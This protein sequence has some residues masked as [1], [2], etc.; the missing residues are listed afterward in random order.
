MSVR[1][2]IRVRPFNEREKKLN[3]ELCVKMSGNTVILLDE[4]DKEAKK[5]NFDYSVWSHDGFITDE[6]GFFKPKDA[7]SKYWDQTKVYN[8]MGNDL[9]ENAVQGY[10]CCLFAYGQTG[11]G[12]SYSIFGYGPNKG[13]VPIMCDRLFD[14]SKLINDDKNQFSISISMLEIYNE[15]IQDLLV[16]VNKR[17]KFGLKVHENPKL[18]VF[19]KGLN[20]LPVNSYEE[21]ENVIA[22]GNKNKTIGSTLMNKTSS[23][24]HTIIRMEIHQKE[25]GLIK[26]IEK[27]SCINLVDLAGSEKVSKTGATGDR[28][29]EACSINKSL[30]NLGIV[31][32]QLVKLQNG[33]KTIVSYRDSVLTR[34][35]QNALGGNSKT[36]MICAI[37]PARDNFDETASTLRYANEAKRIKNNAVINESEVDKMIRELQDENQ[38]LKELLLQLQGTGV[39]PEQKEISNILDQIEELDEAIRVKTGNSGENEEKKELTAKEKKAKKMV[40][41]FKKQF[42]K[43]EVLKHPHI[44]NLSEDMMQSG[45]IIYNFDEISTILVGRNIKVDEENKKVETIDLNSVAISANHASIVYAD[46]NLEIII[47]EENAANNT[48]VNGVSMLEF[49]NGESFSKQL[50]DLDRIIFGTTSTY[51]V[52]LPGV[53]GDCGPMVIEGSEITWDICQMEK[54]EVVKAIEEEQ[55]K[56]QEEELIQKELQFN[57][58]IKQYQEMIKKLE[59]M[60]E[61]KRE[62]TIVSEDVNIVE[63]DENG[64]ITVK[65]AGFKK[66]D[67]IT[68]EDIESQKQAI[69]KKLEEKEVKFRQERERET[70]KKKTTTNI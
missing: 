52:R 5:Y 6:N 65:E 38:R 19:V 67:Q 61:T 45:N 26:T 16:D 32:K 49:W 68:Q 3:S 42:N 21:I 34:I 69:A 44:I 27:F 29:K 64:N 1:V 59:E 70:R 33:E 13:I 37:S 35:L 25:K 17:P 47:S 53:D 4:E 48:T 14:G 54:A 10:H 18:G 60:T 51:L 9:L 40:Q 24:S 55:K 2:A 12:K 28:L 41:M 62:T 11:S 56:V 22:T 36:T 15:K 8:T 50:D 43:D 39:K 57:E 7:L 30:M 23:R 31:I 63:M 46:G 58:E 20:K 66:G